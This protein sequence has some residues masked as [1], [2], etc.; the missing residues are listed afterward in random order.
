MKEK[1]SITPKLVRKIKE[2]IYLI[3]LS[4]TKISDFDNED[5]YDFEKVFKVIEVIAK[6]KASYGKEI[7]GNT[8]IDRKSVSRILHKLRDEG[9]IERLQPKIKNSDRRLLDR[10]EDMWAN[11]MKGIDQFSN[12]KWYG[13]NS[14]HQWVLKVDSDNPD[15]PDYVNEYHI[16]TEFLVDKKTSKFLAEEIRMV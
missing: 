15:D 6:K 4:N 3:D 12:A 7:S 11:D 8:G 2:L 9:Y 14:S 1:S 13:L 10:T 5:Q 16:E